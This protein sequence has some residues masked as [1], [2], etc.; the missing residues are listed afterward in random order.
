MDV[1]VFSVICND[2]CS[3]YECYCT[4]LMGGGRFFRDTVY[5]LQLVLFELNK[6]IHLHTIIQK[7]LILRN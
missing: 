2:F 4:L 5:V 6:F 3:V 1:S 7:L